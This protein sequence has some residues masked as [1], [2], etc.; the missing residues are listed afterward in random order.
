MIPL[1]RFPKLHFTGIGG[2][3]MAPL[4]AWHAARGFSVSGTD[5]EESSNL[6]WLRELGVD[7]RAGHDPSLATGANLVIRTSAVPLDHP[8]IAAALQAGIPVVRRAEAL[9]EVTR[10]SRSLC[11]SGTHGKTTTTLMLGRIL[12]EAG[13]APC[14]LPGGV[15]TD[16]L[17]AIV[18]GATG[19]LVVETDEFDRTFLQFHPDVA[20]VTNLEEDH[21]DCYE[22]LADLDRTFRQF[23]AKLPF[24]GVALLCHDD[25]GSRGLAIGLAAEVL[26]YGFS[27][28]ARLRGTDTDADSFDVHLD[29]RFLTNVKLGIAGRHNR[30][31]ALA[32]LGVAVGEGVH[33]GLAARALEGFRGARRRLDFVGVRG[34]CPVVEDYAH[35][36]TE[37]SATLQA[38]RESQGDRR[39]AIVFQPH[40]YSRTAHFAAAFAGALAA[41]DRAFV[42]PVYPARETPDQGLP[43]SAIVDRAPSGARLELVSGSIEAS[44]KMSDLSH[45][46]DWVL[47]FAGA[48]DVGSWA[49]EFAGKTS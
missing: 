30:L 27:E 36:P 14:V 44:Q 38:L 1:H 9:G 12:R 45:E 39:I 16:P 21:L 17:D 18:P 37:L 29:G 22:D 31:N 34:G 15:P 24:H 19:P 5:R 35:H 33:P 8:E 43:S 7:A 49:H 41:A 4:A 10:S 28:G 26:S 20:V 25:A 47:V 48:G 23:L 13:L 2:A 3:G 11:L 6:A 32:A 42:A 46:G 40:L